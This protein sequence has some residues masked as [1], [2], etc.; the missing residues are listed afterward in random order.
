[1][2][3]LAH[4]TS[5]NLHGIGVSRLTLVI[6]LALIVLALTA[7][8]AFGS[9][10]EGTFQSATEVEKEEPT[11]TTV[12]KIDEDDETVTMAID[13][14]EGGVID[15]EMSRGDVVIDKWDGNSVLV[16]VERMPNTKNGDS[17]GSAVRPIKVKVTRQGKDVRIAA[18]DAHGRPLTDVDLS[19]RVMM[20]RS[21]D[22][23][24]R[25]IREIGDLSK[26]TSVVLRALHR[27]ALHWLF[28]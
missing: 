1:M 23:Q 8:T 10:G 11:A 16:I 7:A 14:E 4:L 13:L 28:R 3:S 20:P 22:K 5:S 21:M 12:Q 19:F 24:D 9:V 6:L 2:R 15:L 27:E 17:S 26:L 25:R 18:L